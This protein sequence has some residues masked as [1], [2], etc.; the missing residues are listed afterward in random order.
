MAGDHGGM[1]GLATVSAHSDRV[2]A[3]RMEKFGL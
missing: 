2:F 1:L 3:I